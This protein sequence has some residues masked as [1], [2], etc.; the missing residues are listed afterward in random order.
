[1]LLPLP[2]E[3]EYQH[4]FVD[5]GVLNGQ[6]LHLS[7]IFHVLQFAFYSLLTYVG[8]PKSVMRNEVLHTYFVLPYKIDLIF[9]V[10]SVS[11]TKH[12]MLY[13][14]RLYHNVLQK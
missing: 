7:D 10:L 8:Q 13:D 3:Q 12:R 9:L 6:T 4:Q 2:D 5:I 1:M 11:L 14:T